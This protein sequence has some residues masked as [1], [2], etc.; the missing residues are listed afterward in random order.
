MRKLLFSFLAFTGLQTLSA[1]DTIRVMSYNILNYS[2]TF[3]EERYNDLKEIVDY[4]NPDVV[5]CQ[6]V[7]NSAGVQLLL[8]NAFN[9]GGGSAW[10]RVTFIDGPDSDNMLFY[11]NSKIKF[12]SQTQ[13]ATDLRNITHYRVYHLLSSTDTAWINLFS[14][15]LK[16]STG[17]ESVRLQECKDLCSYFSGLSASE[18]I[19]VGGDFN[20]YSS[21]TETGFNWLTS[22]SC[23]RRLYD[24]I[25]RIG[26][27]NNN[28]SFKDVH[29]Q[30]TRT[31][32]ESDGGSTGGLDDR[33]DWIFANDRVMNGLSKVRYIPG[34]Y[35][36]VGNDQ[37]HFNL[38]INAAPA[39][40]SAP[41]AVINALYNMS[42][43]LPVYMELAIGNDVGLS[44]YTSNLPGT[45]VKWV[46]TPWLPAINFL[47]DAQT[48]GTFTA[49]V[50]DIMGNLVQSK[51]IEVNEGENTLS[52]DMQNAAKGQYLLKLQGKQGW[53]GCRFM[54]Y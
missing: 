22:T 1:Q 49:N 10:S 32:T 50:Y 43:H 37:N 40:T 46:Y 29:T 4:V 35:K 13:I 39:N 9:P 44:E 12:D 5:I 53:T 47:L 28:A 24:P 8:D 2:S 7:V 3:H 20:F 19:L 16:A 26:N 45:N 34:S 41:T 25:N 18:N 11:K 54:N 17:E 42:D 21:S 36:V 6:E 23:A 30:S 27:W 51:T 33:F 38:A 48:P 14:L 15:H 52:F 31:A